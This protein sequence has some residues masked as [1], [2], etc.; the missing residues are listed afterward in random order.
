VRV[1]PTS[2]AVSV[3]GLAKRFGPVGVLAGLDLEVPAGA[4]VAVLGPSGCG[5]T[6]LLR[7]L[8][9]FE[10]ADAGVVEVDGRRVAG[11]G[12]HLPPER[13]RVGVVPQEQALFPHLSVAGNVGFGLP[14]PARR[15]RVAELLEL[16][17]LTGLEQRMPHELSGGQQQRVALARA[18]APSPSV[19][20]LDEPFGAL[21]T[22]L[23][24]GIRAEVRALLRAAGQTAVLV[25]HDQEEALSLA[26]AVAVLRDGRVVQSGPPTEVYE[27]PADLEVATFL[28][29]ANLLEGER[30][31]DLVHCALGSLPAAGDAPDGPVVVM[32]R[33]ERLVVAA[34]GRT[35]AGSAATA[36][37]GR[38]EPGAQGGRAGPAGVPGRVLGHRYLGHDAVLDVALSGPAGSAGSASGGGARLQVRVWS[39]DLPPGDQ[40]L[41]TAG[42][43]AACFPRRPA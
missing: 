24:A 17:G 37:G 12:L 11:P 27:R 33:P 21:D 31:G 4:L 39:A 14:R 8:A 3:R 22:A 23:R 7:V 29:E 18:L 10:R 13:R 34:G 15:R 30:R 36:L 25:T 35:V 20:L 43:A 38:A 2:G 1:D 40:V 6:T 16:A 28:G 19:V 42:G 9:G 26:D 5:K 32:L 41:V